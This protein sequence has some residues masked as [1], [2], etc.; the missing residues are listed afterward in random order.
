MENLDDI[1]HIKGNKV[2]PAPGKIL[3]SEPFL[4]DHYFKRSVVLLA[5]HNKEGSFGVIINKPMAVDFNEVVKNF[6]GFGDDLYLGGPVSTSNLFYIHTL[7]D[8]I[9]DSVL[10]RKGL[11][12]GGDVERIK[13]LLLLGQLNKHNIRFFVGYAGWMPR[14]LDMELK[15]DSWLVADITT[16]QIMHGSA[17][18]L[19]KDSLLR[20]GDQYRHWI[21]FPS[22]PS[23]N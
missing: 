18:N 14:Q 11:Y 19:W 2:K 6:P 4:F 9:I 10:I 1:L 8:Q 5:D 13:E 20:L 7:G 12:W 16:R 17:E 15:R 22:E 3:I 23:L 21:N